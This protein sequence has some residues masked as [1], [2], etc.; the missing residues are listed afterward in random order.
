MIFTTIDKTPVMSSPIP[1]PI[2]SSVLTE[3]SKEQF[4]QALMNN[5]GAFV[6]K[7]GAEWC[8]PCKK[9]EPLVNSWMSRF[10]PSIQG[11]IIDIDD[12]FEIYAILKSKKQVNG[13]PAILCYK[14]GNFTVIPDHIVVGT[15]ENQINT[16]FHTVLTYA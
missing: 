3:M 16:F 2:C 6:V 5:Q 15:D 12:H 10:P 7:F 8:G 14:K 11:A 4:S 13:V 1:V 9:I